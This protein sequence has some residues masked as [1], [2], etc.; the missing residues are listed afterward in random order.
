[1]H[2]GILDRLDD[3]RAFSG[4][5]RCSLQLQVAVVPS[6]ERRAEV[7]QVAQR[8]F[9]STPVIDTVPELVDHFGALGER[10]VERVYLW[11]SDFAP[12]ETLLAFGADVLPQFGS[13]G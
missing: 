3:M 7:T 5:A 9:G 8:R 4:T 2:I 6:E 13:P 12:P 1:V 11:F 10:G